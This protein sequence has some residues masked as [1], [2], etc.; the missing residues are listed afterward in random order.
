[1]AVLGAFDPHVAGTPPLGLDLPTS[2]ID[3][4]CHAPDPG[5]FAATLW[6][7]FG[8][9]AN[10][11]IRQRV[12]GDRPVIAS[13]T[14]YGWL[15]Q[16]FGQVK[17]VSIQNGWRHFIIERRQL[18]LGGQPFRAAVMRERADGVKTEPAFA[19]VLGL[20]GEPYQAVLDL[21]HNDDAALVRLLAKAGFGTWRNREG[22]P[23]QTAGRL[24]GRLAR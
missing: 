6:K 21:E 16:V 2:D 23:R 19:A 18:A 5:Q 22:K 7:T 24:P 9:Q 4:L 13:F 20:D 11:T 8:A 17:P 14:A 3:V 10:F 15:F 1:M 12:A